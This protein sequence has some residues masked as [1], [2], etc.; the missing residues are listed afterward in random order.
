[1]ETYSVDVPAEQIIRWLLDEQRSEHHDL[2]ISASRS[3]QLE[4]IPS[5]Q[6]ERRRLGQEE[7]EDLTEVI[8]VGI[9]E[10]A[11]LHKKE[12]WLLRIRVEDVLGARAPEDVPTSDEVEEIDLTSFQDE[13]ILPGSGTAFVSTEAQTPEAWSLCQELLASIQSNKHY[14]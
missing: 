11:P 5:S 12:G 8:A 7:V 14:K 9:L 6:Q 1:M 2:Q 3:Y 4:P 13:F 10:V